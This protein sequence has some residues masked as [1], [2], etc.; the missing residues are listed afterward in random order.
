MNLIC[1]IL[2]KMEG[3][4]KPQRKF[5]AMLFETILSMF[6][7]VNFSNLARH[8]LWSAKTF[9][10]N[11]S[12]EFDYLSF[13][14]LLI[15]NIYFTENLFVIGFDQTFI[16][17]SGKKTYGREKFYNG[18]EGKAEKG[19][20]ASG[21]ALIDVKTKK[22]F[23]LMTFQTPTSQEIVD[24]FKSPEA[25]RMDYYTYQLQQLILR[26][27]AK[28]VAIKYVVVDAGISRK[29][30]V[31]GM[32]K[33][34]LETVGKLRSDANLNSLDFKQRQGRGRRK[35]YGNKIDVSDPRNFT[36]VCHLDEE[37]TLLTRDCYSKTLG[38]PIRIAYLQH[39]HGFAILFSTDLNQNSEEII[40]IYQAR[41]Q[42]EFT[43]R[44]AK[45]YTGFT[46]CQARSKPRIHNHLNA[47]VSA[48]LITLVQDVLKHKNKEEKIPFS[49]A[50][51]KQR[52]YNETYMNRIFLIF[53]LDLSLFK[54]HPGFK[55][56]IDYGTIRC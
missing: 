39:K 50:S 56:L 37:T 17:K 42:I 29:K 47:S 5:M 6:G 20:E 21:L 2:G 34:G 23:P 10:R 49:M 30:F 41:Y 54:F 9:A 31:T 27:K 4:S 7:R 8:S 38:V 24:L 51:Y 55:K 44:D 16:E 53:G 52:N 48:L 46:E 35:K 40:A 33:V 12:K 45:Q 14:M 13:N 19:L 28:F 22:S 18:K 11:F 25:T 1:N 26:V 43:F 15:E 3:L 36:F 32:K